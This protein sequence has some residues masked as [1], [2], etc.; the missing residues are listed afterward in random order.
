MKPMSILIVEDEADVRDV[1]N[2]MLEIFGH[3]VTVVSDGLEALKIALAQKFD[4]I[5]TDLGIPGMN[6]LDLVKGIR[7]EKIS[8][9][10]LIITGV[11]FE[12]S[13]RELKEIQPCRVLMKPFRIEDLKRNL[14]SLLESRD[15]ALQ[16]AFKSK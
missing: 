5:I 11:I 1:L 2:E 10:I 4:I 15:G 6:G 14:T 16:K 9:P 8:T 13:D 12:N 3:K 7:K